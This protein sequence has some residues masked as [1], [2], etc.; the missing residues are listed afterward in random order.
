MKKVILLSVLLGMLP[1]ML[2]CETSR[3]LG[4]DIED[5]GEEIGD[6]A[7]DAVD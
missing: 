7:D 2:G 5:A 4:E 1:L 3:G 6:A